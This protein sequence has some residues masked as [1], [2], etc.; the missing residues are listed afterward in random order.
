V[1]PNHEERGVCFDFNTRANKQQK[2]CSA[3]LQFCSN[4]WN[5]ELKSATPVFPAVAWR[6]KGKEAADFSFL[7]SVVGPNN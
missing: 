6:E 3:Q 2:D 7:Y 1:K 4:G 5:K